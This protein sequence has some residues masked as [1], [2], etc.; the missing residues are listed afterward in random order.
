MNS[1]VN[2]K[3]LTDNTI[4]ILTSALSTI[5]NSKDNYDFALDV[6]KETLNNTFPK[7]NCVKVYV[8]TS[9]VDNGIPAICI[10]QMVSNV[11]DVRNLVDYSIEI[12]T[13]YYSN[14]IEGYTPEEVALF[15]IHEIVENIITDNTF[16]RF[17]N[18]IVK[19]MTDKSKNTFINGRNRSI[20]SLLWFGIFSRTKK[21]IVKDTD[22]EFFSSFI[23]E[24]LS[25]KYVDMW[26][27]IVRKYLSINGGDPYQLTDTY[28]DYKDRSDLITFNKFAREYLSNEHCKYPG[29]FE[30]VT[31][32]ILAF[33]NSKLLA[34]IIATKPLFSGEFPGKD[35]Y[36]IFDDS[37]IIYESASD[38][39]SEPTSKSFINRYN[40][41]EIDVNNIFTASEK[42]E[43]AVKLHEF[44]RDIT[45]AL[46]KDLLNKDILESLR[47]KTNTLIHKLKNIDVNESII[48]EFI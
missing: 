36:K 39:F 3:T 10:P 31:K 5:V 46:E 33:N 21:Y 47:S 16:M 26:N 27:G 34:D 8:N 18:I 25:V 38:I 19:Y 9:N 2:D 17:K 37:D 44:N 22:T 1:I 23:K 42:L 4:E 15:I 14:T 45:K 40:E 6:I 7:T 29:Y 11:L 32:Y 20:S 48:E 35:I 30:R 12:N 41:L 13:E 28:L 43:V 24:Y